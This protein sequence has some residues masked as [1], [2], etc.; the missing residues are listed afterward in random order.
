MTYLA[1]NGSLNPVFRATEPQTPRTRATLK[2]HL[3]INIY[4]SI[5]FAVGTN[6]IAFQ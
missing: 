5:G 2:A 6:A 4:A 3:I 1:I